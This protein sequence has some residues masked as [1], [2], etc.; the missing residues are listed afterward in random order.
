[1]AAYTL[2]VPDETPINPQ[3]RPDHPGKMLRQL[4]D[5]RG[6]TGDELADVTGFARTHLS[7]VMSGKVGV[8]PDMAVALAG[9][10][11][12]APS[13]WLRWNAEYQ[14]S[15]V[16]TDLIAVEKRAKLYK[17]API[18]DMQKRGWIRETKSVEDLEAELTRFFGSPIDDGVAFPIATLRSDPLT[19][20]IPSE[21]AWC[22]QAR[23]RAEALVHVAPFDDGRLDA[24]ERKLRQLA[25]YPKEIERLS[26]ILAYYGIRFVVVEPLPGAKIDGAAFWIDGSPCIAVS[27][28]WDRIDAF[29]F[30]VM[31]EFMHI[32]N[33]D[34]RSVDVN[35]IQEG[36]NGIAIRVSVDESEQ[37]ASTQAA[38]ALVPISE[39]ESFIKRTSPLYST[40]RI[41]QFAHRIKMHPG[42]IV[43]QLQHRGELRYSSHR[44]FLVKIRKYLVETALTDGWGQSPSVT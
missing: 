41:V 35:L 8:S 7:N 19:D 4:L 15:L 11:G 6:W 14:L 13:D 12:N 2:G 37:R 26:E 21:Q 25:A 22:F 32:K 44:D 31:H 43:G 39:L 10:F 30:T 34:A 20:L 24:A 9:A 27:A 16:S 38:D 3:E 33:R 40:Q 17:L 23:R 42:I 5:E 28:R 36:D 29:W 18:R 1:M